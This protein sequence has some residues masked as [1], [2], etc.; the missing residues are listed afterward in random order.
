MLVIV[1][2]LHL[3]DG[4]TAD[5]ISPSAFRLFAR[6][7]T[8][9]ARFASWRRDGRYHPIDS[10]DLLLMGDI[11]DPLHS[12]HWLDTSP[13][14]PNY[15]RPW[16]DPNDPH[17]APK[18]LQVTRAI[19]D[20]NEE[21]MRILRRLAS[22][23]EIQL[24]PAT[25]KGE[26]DFQSAE[27]IPLK[28]RIHYMVGNHDWY[29]HLTG[30]AFDEIRRETI[31][32]MGLSNPASPFPYDAEESPFLKD[33]FERHK[34][35]ARHGDMYDK[36]NFDRDKGRD[37]GTVGDAFTMDVCNRFPLEVQKRYGDLLPTGIVDSLRKI[38]NIRPV[39]AAPLWISGQIRHYA[40]SHPLEDE[41]KGVWDDIADEFLQL[42]FVREADKAYR[43]DVVDAMEMIVK[44]SGR[45]SFA[46]INDVV[47][48][49]R[50]K[51]WGGKRSFAGHALK[52]PAF[53]NGKAQHIIYGHTHYYEVVPLGMSV[54][55]AFEAQSQIY[56][57]AGTWHSYYDLAI[58]N[59]KEQKFVP[60]QALTYLTFYTPE[61][62][63][64]RRFET[65][66][67][68]YA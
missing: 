66:S 62:H 12:T 39:L 44:L 53:I 42:D 64:G 34:V 40:G 24:A 16:S 22:G 5:S 36:F 49:V 10:L 37:H 35:S 65:W 61:E 25:S 6:R 54:N 48:W 13:G 33:L 28:V 4:T 23:E 60:Y 31:Q 17:Y 43:F 59:P 56:F 21:A 3:G 9:T 58:Q 27:L 52:E 29:Y 20:K 1:S 51:M 30:A 18:L 26:P 67:G 63:D 2:D 38:A 46:T 50:K 55:D 68:A 15:I 19:L 57:N 45:A 32:R 8:E 14:D 11:I 41:L 47:I 7:L